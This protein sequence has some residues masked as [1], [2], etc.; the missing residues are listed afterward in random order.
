ML[1]YYL[2]K[3]RV[4][5]F[6]CIGTP[7]NKYDSIGPRIGN[8]IKKLG[9]NV[10]GTMDDPVHALNLKKKLKELDK[11]DKTKYQIIAVDAVVSKYHYN[12]KIKNEPCNP[13]AGLNKKLPKIGEITILVNPFYN[14]P[15]LSRFDK[16]RM[17]I[18]NTGFSEIAANLLVSQVVLDIQMSV[19][20]EDPWWENIK[21]ITEK[22]SATQTD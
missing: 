12:Y 10:M 21:E 4:P 18:F 13:G 14:R 17:L 20:G 15:N 9:Y 8:S 5:Y 22:V 19:E 11:L 7:K 1:K 2:D 3:D 6:V 16:K